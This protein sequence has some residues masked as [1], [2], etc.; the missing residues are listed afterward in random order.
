MLSL[1][2]ESLQAALQA[3][4]INWVTRHQSVASHE[5]RLHKRRIYILPTAWGYSYALTVLLMLLG[6]MNYNNSMAFGLS[7]LLVG[8][9]LNAMWYTHRNLLN[10]VVRPEGAAPVFAGDTAEFKLGITNNSRFDRHAIRVQWLE[11][12]ADLVDI[13]LG[14]STTA[15]LKLPALRRGILKPGRFKV[16]SSF[17]LGLFRA[18]SWLE[19]DMTVVVYPKPVTFQGDPPYGADDSNWIDRGQ[20]SGDDL[21]ALRDYRVG[22]PPKRI[23]WKTWAATDKLM[24]KA[25][26]SSDYQEFWLDWDALSGMGEE[27]RLSVLCGILLA[28]QPERVRYGL[29]LPSKTIPPDAGEDHDRR[30][31]HALAVYGLADEFGAQTW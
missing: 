4:F 19:F 21:D 17:P 27:M 8:L 23:A 11:Y 25:F 16:Y 22:D 10:L 14:N 7:F 2:F 29:R 12:D 20:F 28:W 31:L 9:G 6:A 3:R 13:K 30:C 24:S 18:W 1:G 5:I 15:V 26:A